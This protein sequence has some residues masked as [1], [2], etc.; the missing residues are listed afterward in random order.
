MLEL[1]N[2]SNTFNMKRILSTIL[3]I[4]IVLST[5][6]GAMYVAESLTIDINTIQCK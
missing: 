6:I 3:T 5:L 1:I 4:V 2:N